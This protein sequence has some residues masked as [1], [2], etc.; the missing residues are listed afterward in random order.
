M[1]G[2]ETSAFVRDTL[3]RFGYRPLARHDKGVV[4]RFSHRGGSGHPA[5][6]L[7]LTVPPVG[8]SDRHPRATSLHT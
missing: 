7:I 1:S 6:K 3:E 2:T 5:Q 8:R 4:H